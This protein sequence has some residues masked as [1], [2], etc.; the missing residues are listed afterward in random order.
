MSEKR[1]GRRIRRRLVIRFGESEL[2]HAGFTNDVSV[3]GMFIIS[4]FMPPID[5]RLHIKIDAGDGR[6]VYLE[7]IVARQKRVPTALMRSAKGGF[8]VRL[9]TTSELI[10]E[11]VNKNAVA[12]GPPSWSS[13][14]PGQLRLVFPALDGLKKIFEDQIRR[15]GL[16]VPG[17][18]P[19]VAGLE[20]DAQVSVEMVMAFAADASELT[21]PARVLAILP[22]SSPGAPG[23]VALAFIDAGSVSA[24][25]APLIA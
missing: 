14:A 5:S 4:G 23:A 15:G 3:N 22:S 13:P 16:A 10:L 21:F 8:A 17:A 11:L 2:D 1:R 6:F 9:M 12:G 7:G 24:A 25:L 19:G 20:R 18:T